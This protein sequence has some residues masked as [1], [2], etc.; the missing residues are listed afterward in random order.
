MK[1]NHAERAKA[2]AQAHNDLATS[3]LGDTEPD[4]ESVGLLVLVLTDAA[5]SGDRLLLAAGRRVVSRLVDYLPAEAPWREQLAGRLW[6]LQ[7][8]LA[9]AAIL[10]DEEGQFA[11]ST[12]R[13]ATAE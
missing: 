11:R 10:L 12:K 13:L 5:L 4:Q 6:T 7:Q 9:L 3:L 1:T 2:L 8:F